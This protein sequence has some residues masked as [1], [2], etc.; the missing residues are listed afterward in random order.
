MRAIFVLLFALLPAG[1][2]AAQSAPDGELSSG[3]RVRVWMHDGGRVVGAVQS[4]APDTLVLA[5]AD[6]TGVRAIPATAVDHID[7][8]RGR[9]RGR[10][11][12][13]WGVRG[14]AVGMVVGAAICVPDD[15]CREGEMSAV[16]AGLASGIFIGSAVGVYSALAGAIFAGERWE[17]WDAPAQAYVV[18]GRTGGVAVGVTLRL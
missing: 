7:V 9:S 15:D 16:E 6:G 3:T 18:P 2:A 5:P 17:R 8:S 13:R 1:Q 10:S 4:S 14:F 11:A 12:W